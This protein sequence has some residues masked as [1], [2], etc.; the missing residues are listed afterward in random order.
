MTLTENWRRP[1]RELYRRCGRTCYP[2]LHNVWLLVN[3]YI[4]AVDINVSLNLRTW[5]R[6]QMYYIIWAIYLCFKN[7]SHQSWISSRLLQ[8]TNL[9]SRIYRQAS[10][11]EFFLFLVNFFLNDAVSSSEQVAQ[12]GKTINRESNYHFGIFLEW[13]RGKR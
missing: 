13:L 12:N 1:R 6:I 2:S 10:H 9:N 11:G 4:Q 7:S 3:V 5:W 8:N